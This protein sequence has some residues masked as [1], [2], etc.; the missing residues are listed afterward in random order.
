M[1]NQKIWRSCCGRGP[2]SNSSS[3][4]EKSTG[5]GHSFQ[6]QGTSGALLGLFLRN[7]DPLRHNPTLYTPAPTSS[8][9][10][11]YQASSFVGGQ[12]VHCAVSAC[13]FHADTPSHHTSRTAPV[14]VGAA[15]AGSFARLLRARPCCFA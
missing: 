13:V 1:G 15:G 2:H 6:F 5:P 4:L 12:G 10:L 8:P 11:L 7:A 14:S 9:C 3:T